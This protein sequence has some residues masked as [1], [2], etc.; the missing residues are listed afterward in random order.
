MSIP[1]ARTSPTSNQA[2]GSALSGDEITSMDEASTF[3]IYS[4]SGTS[5]VTT[6]AVNAAVQTVSST[7]SGGGADDRFEFV[8]QN[9]EIIEYRGGAGDDI[10]VL[11]DDV[12]VGGK[13]NGQG[14]NDTLDYSAYGSA[15]SVDLETGTATNILGKLA[16]IETVLGS[17]FGDILIG[18]NWNNYLFGNDGDD[19]LIGGAGDDLLDGGAGSDIFR[20]LEDWGNDIL[21]DLSGLLD[22]V[23]F[24]QIAFSLT[25]TLAF[26]GLVVNRQRQPA[27]HIGKQYRSA[28]RRPG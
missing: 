11:S 22:E 12:V 21:N 9:D 15:V 20:F 14:G 18:D 16:S 6:G 8:E 23:D 3:G 19:L 25:F 13:I 17:A 2:I 10:F 4:E 26:S 1:T 27:D 28:E 24:S 5:Q 7:S